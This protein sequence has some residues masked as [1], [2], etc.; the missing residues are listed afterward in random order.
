MNVWWRTLLTILRAKAMLRRNG[1]AHPATVGRVRVRTLPTDID[2][3]G[4][5]NNGRYASLFDLGRFDLLI[6]T[7]M[8]DLFNARG[9]YAVVA[10]ETITF[11]KSL[12]LW[13]R[14]TVESRL[15][16][17][18]DKS[19]YMIHRAVV[20]GEIYAEMLVRARFLR[21]GGG[22]VPLEELFEALHR[23]D[24][25]PPLEPWMLQWAAESALPSTKSPAPSVWD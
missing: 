23:P 13:Q 16:G 4:H 5:M 3:L 20:N 7:G 10:S 17:H 18:D 22:I 24:D 21:R 1:A 2:L 19:V 25:L 12:G 6:R 9:W 11:R 8:W 14:F 15:H